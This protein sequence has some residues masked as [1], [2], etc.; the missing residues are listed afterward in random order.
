M[1]NFGFVG[2]YCGVGGCGVDMWLARE[3]G[4]SIIPGIEEKMI[5][6]AF[7]GYYPKITKFPSTIAKFLIHM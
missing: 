3:R 4:F 5:G 6:P 1:H 7:G 2:V